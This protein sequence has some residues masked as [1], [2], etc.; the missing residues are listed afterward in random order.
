[1]TTPP[2]PDITEAVA[3]VVQDLKTVQGATARI[4]QHPNTWVANLTTTASAAVAAV[5]IWHPG[6]S[7]KPVV[8]ATVGST[9]MIGAVAA[10]IAHFVSRRA[11]QTALKVAGK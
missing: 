5:T 3:Q 1:M 7:E 6:F 10:Q 2:Q 11:A 9:A 8:Q 4:V